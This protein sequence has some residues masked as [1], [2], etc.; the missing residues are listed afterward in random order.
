[1]LPGLSG[2]PP[3][4]GEERYRKRNTVGRAINKPKNSRSVATRCEERGYVFPGTG[5][6]AA[7][8]IRSRS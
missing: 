4:F 6:A 5:T 1:M 8:G 2:R 7:L 3:G